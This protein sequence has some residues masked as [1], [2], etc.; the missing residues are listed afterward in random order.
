[1]RVKEEHLEELRAYCRSVLQLFCDDDERLL[2]LMMMSVGRVLINASITT[3]K[4]AIFDA[5]SSKLGHVH[6]WLKAAIVNDAP[7]L[8]KVD[9]QKRPR[10]LMK[11]S[12]LD[13]IV[14]EADKDML[15]IASRIGRSCDREGDVETFCELSDGYSMVR[16]LTPHALDRESHLMQHCIG[17]GSYDHR[18]EMENSH[19]LSLRDRFGNPHATIDIDDGVIEQIS[20]KQNRLPSRKYLPY[21]TEFLRKHPEFPAKV[22]DGWDDYVIDANGEFH[23]LSSLPP[24]LRRDGDLYL[25][26][27]MESGELVPTPFHIEATGEVTVNI[28]NFLEP[29][30]SISCRRLKMTGGLRSLDGATVINGDGATGP[31]EELTL[32]DMADLKALPESLRCMGN[33]S[34]RATGLTQLPVSLFDAASTTPKGL[35]ISMS[36][37]ASIGCVTTVNG[38]FLAAGSGLAEIPPSL[39]VNGKMDISGTKAT[40]KGNVVVAQELNAKKSETTLS[41]RLKTGSGATFS[42][43]VITFGERFICGGRLDLARSE[44]LRMPNVLVCTGEL[45]MRDVICARLPLVLRAK[46]LV[47]SGNEVSVI[48]GDVKVDTLSLFDGYRMEF[49]SNVRIGQVEFRIRSSKR[50]Y[51]MPFAKA[52]QYMAAGFRSIADIAGNPHFEVVSSDHFLSEMFEEMVWYG[53]GGVRKT[54]PM[55]PPAPGAHFHHLAQAMGWR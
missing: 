40:F 43:S 17:H 32:I 49:G 36:P 18:L 41:S 50:T 34:L 12:T 1:M 25:E 31:L 9:D 8:S 37:I 4:D 10:K 46:K 27:K 28:E 20:G 44:I 53:D 30:K 35:D 2:A 55:A 26:E 22:G 38:H 47:L 42:D 33:I 3:G 54:I 11:F 13:G 24:T 16:L 52:V 21:V 45:V 6:D 19:F 29:I 39:R 7:W 15:K 23:E 48:D 14:A 5:P 51:T